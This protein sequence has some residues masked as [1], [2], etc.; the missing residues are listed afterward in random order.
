[1]NKNFLQAW[2]PD[3]IPTVFLREYQ[4]TATTD[5]VIQK[6]VISKLLASQ[7]KLAKAKKNKKDAKDDE[8]VMEELIKNPSISVAEVKREKKREK[9]REKEREAKASLEAHEKL[10]KSRTKTKALKLNEITKAMPKDPK[11]K[12]MLMAVNRILVTEK[13]AAV[14]GVMSTRY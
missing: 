14:G 8:I 4:P 11:E 5:V 13:S 3:E 12:M 9:D 6:Q 7:I 1:M 2:V 10:T